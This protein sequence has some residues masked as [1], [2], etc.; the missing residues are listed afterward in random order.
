MRPIHRLRDVS[1]LISVA[2]FR[3]LA[4]NDVGDGKNKKNRFLYAARNGEMISRFV[5]RLAL[6]RTKLQMSQPYVGPEHAALATIQ[7]TCPS[8]KRPYARLSYIRLCFK[9]Q[10]W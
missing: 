9:T 1:I 2:V 3:R 4:G 8:M 7:D 5:S 10:S 6:H